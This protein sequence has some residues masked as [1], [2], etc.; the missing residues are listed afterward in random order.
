MLKYTLI[1]L[2][3]ALLGALLALLFLG[4]VDLLSTQKNE[5]V[6]LRAELVAKNARG[7]EIRLPA[8]TTLTFES[9]YSD[10]ATLGVRVVTSKLDAFEQGGAAEATYYAD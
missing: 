5:T 10:E 6:V 9:Q 3:G 8:G 7:G 2:L 4:D 1:G